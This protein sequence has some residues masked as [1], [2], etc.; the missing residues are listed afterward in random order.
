[1]QGGFETG[2]VHRSRNTIKPLHGLYLERLRWAQ[3]G[4]NQRPPD[5]EFL[6]GFSTGSHRFVS[7]CTGLI[8]FTLYVKDYTDL[9]GFVETLA[10]KLVH[11][12]LILF[13]VN[14]LLICFEFFVQLFRGL[15]HVAG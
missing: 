1:M 11:K 6:I 2:W 9:H 13:W 4:S 10:P 8:Y 7:S 3:M 14:N 15:V 12:A 5:Y